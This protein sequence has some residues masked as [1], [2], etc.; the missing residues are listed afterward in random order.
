MYTRADRPKCHENEKSGAPTHAPPQPGRSGLTR[1][2]T[3]TAE[4]FE[5]AV[6]NPVLVGLDRE[7]L[8][9]WS[10]TLSL[11]CSTC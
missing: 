11:R 7:S 1:E 5:I 6:P 10:S 4:A 3:Q 2:A 8:S 9:P